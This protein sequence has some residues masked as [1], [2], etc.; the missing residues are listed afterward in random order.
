MSKGQNS[1][2][3]KTIREQRKSI[4]RNN[5]GITNEEF[6]YLTDEQIKLTYGRFCSMRMRNKI[7]IRI[8]KYFNMS[9][10]DIENI[11]EE[12]F[13]KYKKIVYVEAL[14]V[15]G[16]NTV[17]KY[18]LGN[19]D[20]MSDEELIKFSGY[21]K[22][23]NAKKRTEK[24]KKN[25]KRKWKITHFKN[26]YS[27]EINYDELS[28]EQIDDLYRNYLN[29]SG[30]LENTTKK[31]RGGKWNK[32]WFHSD[33]FNVDVFYRSSYEKYFL[34]F[35]ENSNIIKKIEFHLNGIKYIFKNQSHW[36]FPDFLINDIYL[37]EIKAKYQL[38]Q[39]Q[40]QAKF[41]AG[42]Q[43]CIDK[44]LTYLILTEDNL[45]GEDLCKLF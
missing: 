36:Y 21:T 4:F 39:E 10:S 42:I 24:Q 13:N 28:D 27:K 37:V 15:C 18:E 45:F 25:D 22:G 8:Q 9:S 16:K 20:E 17:I 41:Q 44:E 3:P 19:P 6:E 35:C 1:G 33:K 2:S 31:G 32:G 7:L 23:L 11:S 34:E 12:D 5:L 38:K 40:T 26:Y 43:Y 30:R 29:D 14:K